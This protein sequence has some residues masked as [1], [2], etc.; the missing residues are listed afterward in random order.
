MKS[1]SLW[2]LAD[3][4]EAPSDHPGLGELR[5]RVSDCRDVSSDRR[6]DGWQKLLLGQ[7]LRQ[8]FRMNREEFDD[9]V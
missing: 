4:R 6:V 9:A 3:D 7:P 8:P 2:Q 1:H 5:K